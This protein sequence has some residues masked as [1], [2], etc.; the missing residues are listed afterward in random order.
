VWDPLRSLVYYSYG[1]D[2][3]TVL[4][5]GRVVLRGGRSVLVDETELLH[6]ASRGAERLCQT[7]LDLGALQTLS[8]PR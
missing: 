1:T 5:D 6:A 4:V 7:A 3:D 8:S 2:V